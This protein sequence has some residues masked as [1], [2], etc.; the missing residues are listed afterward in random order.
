MISYSES[1]DEGFYKIAD[2][3][4][5]IIYNFN[6]GIFDCLDFHNDLLFLEPLIF[7][8]F[9]SPDKNTSLDQILWGYIDA[10]KR[11]LLIEVTSNQDGVIY[12]P[13]YGFLRTSRIASTLGLKWSNNVITLYE[14]NTT[15]S[16]DFE[17]TIK[18]DVGN[19]IVVNNQIPLIEYL[20]GQKDTPVKILYNDSYVSLVNEAFKIIRKFNPELFNYLIKT[21]R[22]IC[23]YEGEQNSFASI[24]AHGFIF[25]NMNS[26]AGLVFVLD[27][28]IHQ[29]CHVI[30]NVISFE[31][32]NWFTVPPN[33]LLSAIKP[34]TN[35]NEELYGRYHGLFT[36]SNINK[37]LDLCIESRLF[38]GD[39]ELELLGRFASNMTRFKVALEKLQLP[40]YTPLGEQWYNHFLS[41]HK[42]LYEKRKGLIEKYQLLNQPYVFD[43]EL[44]KRTNTI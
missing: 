27:N 35:D 42:F 37:T 21:L 4:R 15:V 6:S 41:T 31:K 32:E 17:K 28:I 18:I 38:K 24:A 20:F 7:T 13:N 12:L 26:K 40:I 19:I 14:G 33:T 34:E 3:I 30:F 43:F 44:F 36:Q 1:L 29:G 23:F 25:L 2:T 5:N 11:P 9:N 39:L 10:N 8:Y 16:Y 22:G